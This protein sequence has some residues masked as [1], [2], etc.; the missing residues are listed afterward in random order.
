[1][2]VPVVITLLVRHGAG[3]A[4][5]GLPVLGPAFA[6]VLMVAVGA[7]MAQAGAVWSIAVVTG[8]SI[9]S[10]QIGYLAGIAIRHLLTAARASRLRIASLT[11][12]LPA[13]RT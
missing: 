4:A 13:R 3:A 12:P 7:G 2:M 8:A 10:L 9:A 11:R 6:L 5:S 1:M